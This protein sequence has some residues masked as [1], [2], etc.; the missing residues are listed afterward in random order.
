[1][2]CCSGQIAYHCTQGLS[3]SCHSVY[4]FR[5][6]QPKRTRFLF[7]NHI[8]PPHKARN[9]SRTIDIGGKKEKYT[10]ETSI[11]LDL[12]IDGDDASK[13]LCAYA[14]TFQVDLANFE[15]DTYFGEEGCSPFKAL[16]FLVVK[17]KKQKPLTIGQLLTGI[18]AGK[19]E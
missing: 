19:L 2:G 17:R 18:E 16:Y 10:S 5:C 14:D 8:R 4:V 13:F 6:K 12:G 3:G 9:S 15:F 11:N 1:N 7:F